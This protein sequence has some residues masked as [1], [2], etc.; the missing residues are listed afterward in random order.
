MI[1][2]S[3]LAMS[4]L[5]FSNASEASMNGQ[6]VNGDILDPRIFAC[7][8]TIDGNGGVFLR[9]FIETSHQLMGTYRF[10]ITS[11]SGSNSNATSQTNRFSGGSL[12]SSMV[13]IGRASQVS[14][15]L[16][17]R[18][19]NGAALCRVTTNIDLDEGETRL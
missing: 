17:V 18:E 5:L 1:G 16:E 6:T 4:L 10:T 2:T 7:G 11:R 19:T 13:G 8:V 14:I 9:P 12:G 3:L 15:D